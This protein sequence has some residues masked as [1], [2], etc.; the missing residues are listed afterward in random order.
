MRS[1]FLTVLSGFLMVA[2]PA[3][4][5]PPIPVPEPA[6]LGVLATG[7]VVLAAIRLRRRK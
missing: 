7:A 5:A 6:S 1:G 3:F 2:A 4:A